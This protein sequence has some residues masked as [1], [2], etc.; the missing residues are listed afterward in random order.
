M[1]DRGEALPH[2]AG[3]RKGKGLRPALRAPLQ[4]PSR[5]GRQAGSSKH[6]GRSRRTAEMKMNWNER[7]RVAAGAVLLAAALFAH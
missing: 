3:G 7:L 2:C 6:R 4:P 1:T 5:C